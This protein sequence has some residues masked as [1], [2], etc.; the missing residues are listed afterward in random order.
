MIIKCV[1][2]AN[3]FWVMFGSWTFFFNWND[4]G[5]DN[6]NSSNCTLEKSLWFM[7]RLDKKKNFFGCMFTCDF[8]TVMACFNFC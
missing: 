4:S 1:Y 2:D 6:I 5:Y 3:S 8:T 7:I